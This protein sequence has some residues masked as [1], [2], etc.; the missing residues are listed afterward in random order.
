MSTFFGGCRLVNFCLNSTQIG[1]L[2]LWCHKWGFFCFQHLCWLFNFFAESFHCCSF[3]LNWLARSFVS[4]PQI[5][6]WKSQVVTAQGFQSAKEATSANCYRVAS[7]SVLA[8][9]CQ[10]LAGVKEW[11]SSVL[12]CS[13][14]AAWLAAGRVPVHSALPQSAP[15]PENITSSVRCSRSR[16]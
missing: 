5:H 16:C 15:T 12:C 10:T 7:R 11:T 4:I 1:F 6:L 13:F 8:N 2:R 14:A 3:Q 9:S